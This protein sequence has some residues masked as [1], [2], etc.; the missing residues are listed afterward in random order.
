MRVFGALTIWGLGAFRVR[1]D[2][3]IFFVAGG[4]GGGGCLGFKGFQGFSFFFFFFFFFYDFQGFSV[5]GPAFITLIL[6]F[7]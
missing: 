2:N 1:F 5:K 4:G 3:F 7:W 6:T